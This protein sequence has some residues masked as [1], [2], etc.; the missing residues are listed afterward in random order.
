[1]Q[2]PAPPLVANNADFKHIFSSS[3]AQKYVVEVGRTTRCQE[4]ELS[5]E[6][7]VYRVAAWKPL[8]PSV[9]GGAA[10]ATG[11][12]GDRLTDEFRTIASRTDIA[13]RVKQQRN[14]SVQFGF[15]QKRLG[16]VRF[17]FQACS[18]VSRLWEARKLAQAFS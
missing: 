7:V 10:V 18:S 5:H 11:G 16:S 6:G 9:A 17:Q 13:K 8:S 3:G 14:G 4:L 2:M 12:M 15:C 1:M